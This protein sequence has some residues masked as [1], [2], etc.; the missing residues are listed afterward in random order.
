M[1]SHKLRAEVL[2][3]V[4]AIAGLLGVIWFALAGVAQAQSG[5][6]A[7]AEQG[8][9]PIREVGF[10]PHLN[11]QLPLDLA[12]NDENGQPVRLRDYFTTR[13]VLLTLN[14]YDCQT[15]ARWSSTTWSIP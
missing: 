2:P 4:A 5:G 10:D 14:Y 13:P 9:A 6:P 15:C 8:N 11:A 1:M 3:R 12:F 7:G